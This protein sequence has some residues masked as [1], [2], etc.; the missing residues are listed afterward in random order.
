[1]KRLL[2]PFLTLVLCPSAQAFWGKQPTTTSWPPKSLNDDP[3]VQVPFF[4]SIK[5]SCAHFH[6]IDSADDAVRARTK[7]I[8]DRALDDIQAGL[9]D[10]E[11]G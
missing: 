8:I 11:E 10:P 2:I 7:P 6:A 9:L 4:A 1:M 5:E 3:D